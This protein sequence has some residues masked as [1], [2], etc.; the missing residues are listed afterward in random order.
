MGIRVRVSLKYLVEIDA[1][2]T[3]VGSTN[4]HHTEETVSPTTEK[5]YT[6]VQDEQDFQPSGH[7]G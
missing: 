1:D 4:R 2:A 7:P 3:D 6:L 5:S